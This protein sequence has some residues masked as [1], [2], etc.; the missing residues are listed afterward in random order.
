MLVVILGEYFNV[1]SI[2]FAGRFISTCWTTCIIQSN[3][4]KLLSIPQVFIIQKIKIF[5]DR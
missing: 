1:V 5:I 3:V 4:V 2:N